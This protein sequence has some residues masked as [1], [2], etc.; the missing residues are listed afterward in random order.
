[1]VGVELMDRLVFGG[2]SGVVFLLDQGGQASKC[3]VSALVPPVCLV[4]AVRPRA[5]HL[6]LTATWLLQLS[7]KNPCRPSSCQV[8]V[9]AMLL[10]AWVVGVK[11]TLGFGGG[12]WVGVGVVGGDGGVFV[13]P[14]GQASKCICFAL[15]PPVC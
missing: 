15:S 7:C 5:P 8:K 10:L 2:G 9:G 6:S 13:T 4:P 14:S 3:I 11:T 1:M 12:L